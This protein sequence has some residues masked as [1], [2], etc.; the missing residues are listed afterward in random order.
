M[1]KFR[2]VDGASELLLIKND[3]GV[4]VSGK[5]LEPQYCWIDPASGSQLHEPK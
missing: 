3:N 4:W 1:S 5:E 2:A